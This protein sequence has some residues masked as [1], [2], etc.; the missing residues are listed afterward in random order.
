MKFYYKSRLKKLTDEEILREFI[1]RFWVNNQAM[2]LGGNISFKN[3]FPNPFN[4][5]TK[6]QKEKEISILQKEKPDY[7]RSII[8]IIKVAK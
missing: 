4:G 3:P 5:L 7:W 1:V 2:D 8:E 6:E